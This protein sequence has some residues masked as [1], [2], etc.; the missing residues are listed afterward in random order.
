MIKKAIGTCEIRRKYSLK[1]FIY[2]I[3]FANE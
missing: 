1:S 2:G 3:L